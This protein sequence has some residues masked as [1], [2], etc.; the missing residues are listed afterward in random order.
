[1][2]KKMILTEREETQLLE[3]INHR[4]DAHKPKSLKR[5]NWKY[6]LALPGAALLFILLFIPTLLNGIIEK[7]TGGA[8]TPEQA[9]EKVYEALN[10]RDFETF[11]DLQSE[12][13]KKFMLK[14]TGLTR[15]E[16]IQ[17]QKNV[18]VQSVE[19]KKVEK[20]GIESDGRTLVAAT[21]YTP[22]STRGPATTAV[23]KYLVIKE[24]GQW[25]IDETVSME[26]VEWDPK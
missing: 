16:F 1:M 8:R 7:N 14:E 9:V 5:S 18:N 10:S 23:T 21:I 20:L 3:S 6:R 22:L 19:V 4:I 25:K 12:S 2:K 24:D 17:A 26:V 11:Y 15:E 13:L